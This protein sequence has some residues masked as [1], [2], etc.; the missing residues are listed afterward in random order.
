[1]RLTSRGR[2]IRN[3]VA[4]NL[5]DIINMIYDL[6]ADVSTQKGV[7]FESLLPSM[8]RAIEDYKKTKKKVLG[9]R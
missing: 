1:M 5:E 2:Q 9:I 6:K 4:Q 7:Y 3:E 8:D